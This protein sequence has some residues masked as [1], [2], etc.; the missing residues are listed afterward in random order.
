[1][2]GLGIVEKTGSGGKGGHS[3]ELPNQINSGMKEVVQK[4]V[5][6]SDWLSI[7]ARV[8]ECL[9]IALRGRTQEDYDEKEEYDEKEDYEDEEYSS[10]NE[11]IP[12]KDEENPNE[13][14]DKTEAEPRENPESSQEEIYLKEEGENK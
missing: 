11:M 1:M 7:N 4:K 6:V 3:S 8:N 12:A 9:E 5:P 2:Q 14:E 13:T 10:E